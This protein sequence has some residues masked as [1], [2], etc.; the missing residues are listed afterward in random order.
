[1][2]KSM[3]TLRKKSSAGFAMLEALVGLLIFS[4][5]ILGVVGLQA[6]MTKAQSQSRFRA[7]AAA[8]AGDLIGTMWADST[9]LVQYDSTHCDTYT[10]CRSWA[11]KVAGAL[12]GGVPQVAV[13]GN[14]VT[15]TLAWIVPGEAINSQYVTATAVTP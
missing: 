3:P 8:L 10:P 4:F 5:G 6:A 9:N 13:N 15:I 12:P 7:G 11:S 1:M 14:Q 2:S